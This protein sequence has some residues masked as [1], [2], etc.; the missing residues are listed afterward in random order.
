L[1]ESS[2]EYEP[3]PRSGQLA[4]RRVLALLVVIGK[5]HDPR[6][7]SAWAKMHRLEMFLSTEEAAFVA[8][9]DP[10]QQ[11]KIKFS[12]RAEAVVSLIWA[13]NGL[14][15][16]PPFNEE[17]DLFQIPM[18]VAAMREPHTFISQAQ[19]RDDEEIHEMEMH[20][21]HQHWRVRDVELGFNVGKTLEP[22]PND[23]P[24]EELNP[25]IV[26]E[27]RYAL[28]WLVGHGEDWDDVPTDT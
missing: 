2:E 12:W 21:H 11:D 4:A 23:P 10:S 3:T 27:R 28:S 18:I 9:S 19:L 8:K 15:E 1:A 17:A 26:H 7:S 6:Q 20:L 24:I 13:L 22:G 16:M 14:S 25:G 5:V